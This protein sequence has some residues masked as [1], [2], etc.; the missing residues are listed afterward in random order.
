M[1]KCSLNI[2]VEYGITYTVSVPQDPFKIVES[3]IC[4]EFTYSNKSTKK[5]VTVTCNRPLQGKYIQIVAST[6]SET[7][8][9]VFEI[10]RFGKFT[11][12][13]IFR[14]IDNKLFYPQC[15]FEVLFSAFKIL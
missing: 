14:Y 5:T 9:K 12:S 2:L 7:T 6:Q 8:L 13:N 4:S 10:S 11:T 1:S 15:R 3:E